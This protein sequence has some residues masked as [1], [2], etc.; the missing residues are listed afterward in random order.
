MG[1]VF[2]KGKMEELDRLFKAAR[3]AREIS[4]DVTAL[5]HYEEISAIVPD[6][7]EAMFYLVVLKTNTIK[8]GEIASAATSV[9]NAIPKVFE[10]IKTTIDDEQLRKDAVK[11]V[12]SQCY[13]TASWLTS[14]ST[15]FYNSVTQGNGALALTGISGIGA[16][17]DAKQKAR[18]ESAKR[19]ANIANIMCV[20]G[21]S[22]EAYFDLNDQFY[23]DFAVFSWKKLLDMHYEHITLHK[24]AVFND[25][26][27]QKFAS[28]IQEFDSSY[29]LPCIKATGNRNYN[30]LGIILVILAFGVGIL[31]ALPYLNLYF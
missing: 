24:T 15:N 8:Y 23:R 17:M 31:I 13:K 28:K 3:N 20:C 19:S 7:W 16:A 11:E 6:S 4:D 18:Y 14:A 29:T 21:N 30:I 22:I 26:S 2:S 10:L 1:E 5:K 12:V 27:V 25:E 9:I